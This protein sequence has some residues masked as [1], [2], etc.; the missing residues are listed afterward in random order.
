[1][2]KKKFFK[3]GWHGLAPRDFN[4]L[5]R[6][7]VFPYTSIISKACFFA[8]FFEV[9]VKKMEKDSGKCGKL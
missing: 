4:L 6:P 1:M 9:L 8:R 2:Q 5:A 7:I 3:M